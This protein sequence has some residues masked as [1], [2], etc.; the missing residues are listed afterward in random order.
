MK[1]K[2]Y[3]AKKSLANFGFPVFCCWVQDLGS[4]LNKRQVSGSVNISEGLI[5]EYLGYRP[6][7]RFIEM[8]RFCIPVIQKMYFFLYRQNI[9]HM[10]KLS[11]YLLHYLYCYH[12][13]NGMSTLF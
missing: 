9:I 10:N 13:I 11:L 4:L 7:E 5:W 12:N 2:L 1:I 6:A 8:N 3:E